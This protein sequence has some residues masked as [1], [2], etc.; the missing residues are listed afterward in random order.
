MCSSLQNSS[1]FMHPD[2]LATKKNI[3]K[4][5]SIPPLCPPLENTSMVLKNMLN[6]IVMLPKQ[7]QSPMAHLDFT[8]RSEFAVFEQATRYLHKL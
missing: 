5:P 3:S 2:F 6:R 4:T 8:P 7:L 1:R